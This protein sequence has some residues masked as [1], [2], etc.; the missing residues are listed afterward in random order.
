[1]RIAQILK[2]STAIGFAVSGFLLPATVAGLIVVQALQPAAAYYVGFGI[3]L[4]AGQSSAIKN[5]R[6][7]N[8]DVILKIKSYAFSANVPNLRIYFVVTKKDGTQ[9]TV[10]VVKLRD[11]TFDREF[12]GATIDV[13]VVR[14][15][16]ESVS[17]FGFRGH[18]IME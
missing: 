4:D 12:I 1:M 5:I 11:D 18:V 2:A 9:Q 17:P 14:P 13:M 16:L 6:W 10:E 3:R 15:T 7:R 8:V